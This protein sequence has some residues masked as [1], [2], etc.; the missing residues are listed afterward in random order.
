M[1]EKKNGWKIRR[2]GYKRE[3]GKSGNERRGSWEGKIGSRR[4]AVTCKSPR[5]KS[6]LEP[7]EA[8]A[9]GSY[10]RTEKNS[11]GWRRTISSGHAPLAGGSAAVHAAVRSCGGRGNCRPTVP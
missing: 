6:R 1:K 7:T 11:G 9:A 5:K 3:E 2:T 8:D 4:T 10:E